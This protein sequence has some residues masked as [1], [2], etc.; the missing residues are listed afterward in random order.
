MLLIREAQMDQFR[1]EV[2]EQ[3]IDRASR[4][5]AAHWPAVARDTAPA[6][7]RALVARAL[8]AGEM[9][10][11]LTE[12]Q[13]LRFVNLTVALGEGFETQPRCSWA[14][15]ILTNTALSPDSKLDLLFAR[16]RS[17]LLEQ[18]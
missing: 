11:F 17:A 15:P 13:A 1:R 4:T 7:L 18:A 8:A 2:R 6:G 9:L 14:R 12:T 16:A 5:V 3:F 10:G